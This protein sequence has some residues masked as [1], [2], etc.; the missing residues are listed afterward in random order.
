MDNGLAIHPSA[1]LAGDAIVAAA[2]LRKIGSGKLVV[3][4]VIRGADGL[5]RERIDVAEGEVSLDRAVTL[6]LDVPRLGTRETT[7]VVRLDRKVIAR[8]DGDTA[9]AEPDAACVGIVHR[10][11]GLQATLHVDEL[12]LTERLR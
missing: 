3:G 8:I 10:H 6:D 7:A 4:V 9:G 5:F 11:A 12:L 1:F 2:C